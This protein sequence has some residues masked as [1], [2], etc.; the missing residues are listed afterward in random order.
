M[1]IIW[2]DQ[3]DLLMLYN[4][5]DNNLSTLQPFQ[6]LGTFPLHTGSSAVMSVCMNYIDELH[7]C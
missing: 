1:V 3:K 4:S 5:V 6:Q 2:K 7:F